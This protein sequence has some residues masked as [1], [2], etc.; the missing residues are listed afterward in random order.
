MQ[1]H[2]V[3]PLHFLASEFRSSSCCL[4][5]VPLRG[6][7]EERAAVVQRAWGTP[8]HLCYLPVWK[9]VLQIGHSLKVY[10]AEFRKPPLNRTMEK[11]RKKGGGGKKKKK[12]KGFYWAFWVGTT[13]G[14]EHKA[15]V[16][17]YLSD[18][19][20]DPQS[21][22]GYH[23]PLCPQL[24]NP[25]CASLRKPKGGKLDYNIKCVFL[26]TKNIIWDLKKIRLNHSPTKRG[27]SS[28]LPLSSKARGPL[29]NAK[30]RLCANVGGIWD[31]TACETIWNVVSLARQGK[32]I[33]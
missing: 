1:K 22:T 21:M 28:E 31:L 3:Q 4:S 15:Q 10:T 33:R 25:F 24:C 17:H 19:H 32:C 8:S 11:G 5:W 29:P 12:K 18:T 26:L 14:P 6:E 30:Q 2:S 13:R 27:L 7:K 9:G 23:L 20:P 16:K